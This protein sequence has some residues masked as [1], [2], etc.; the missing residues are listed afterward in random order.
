MA[1]FLN[2]SIGIISAFIG[3]LP[4]SMLNMT[5]ARTSIEKNTKSA[6]NF[7]IGASVV[8][9]AQAFIALSFTNYLN[10]FP[11]ILVTLQKVALVIF[12]ALSFFFFVQARK[13]KQANTAK[14]KRK[15]NDFAGGVLLSS[16]NILSIPYY[17]GLSTILDVEGWVNLNA[18]F[19]Y[20]FI[21]GAALGTFLLL[22]VYINFAK[23][24]ERRAAYIARNINYILSGLSFLLFVITVFKIV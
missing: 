20:V 9:V 17:C 23:T 8:V 16:L 6:I 18:P 3:L 4:P 19:N 7:A 15:N 5:A 1:F 12:L 2:F 21:T 11:D 24:I 13:K 10:T 22:L 14:P